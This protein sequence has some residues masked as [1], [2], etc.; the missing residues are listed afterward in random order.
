M[1]IKQII[2]IGVSSF[3]VLGQSSATKAASHNVKTFLW[4]TQYEDHQEVLLTLA[5]DSAHLDC[6]QYENYRSGHAEATAEDVD[7]ARK[8]PLAGQMKSRYEVNFKIEIPILK[9]AIPMPSDHHF[10]IP[11]RLQQP[12]VRLKLAEIQDFKVLNT[13]FE[14]LSHQSQLLGLKAEKITTHLIAS[15]AGAYPVVRVYERDTAC[16]LLAARITLQAKVAYEVSPQKEDILK[17]NN[18]THEVITQ[19]KQVKPLNQTNTKNL[20]SESILD[21][22]QQSALLGLRLANSAQLTSQ[23]M[24]EYLKSVFDILFIEGSLQLQDYVEL[25]SD[26]WIL[27]Y[28]KLVKTPDHS[29]IL[30][31]KGSDDKQNV[32]R[33]TERIESVSVLSLEAKIQFI[34]SEIKAMADLSYDQM[35]SAQIEKFNSLNRQRIELIKKKIWS[36]YGGYL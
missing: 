10:E 5:T 33:A 17:M 20:P 36:Q 30:K 9:K 32:S 22:R 35:T 21:E 18:W 3:L 15:G 8:L 28:P 12:D 23:K 4:Q 27:N 16:D 34:E 7:F 31:L 14:S 26:R 13:S 6:Q 2:T 25:F 11:F 24:E 1:K 19:L 29:V